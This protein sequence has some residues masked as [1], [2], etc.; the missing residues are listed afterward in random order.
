M[1]NAPAA[2]QALDV[3][4]LLAHRGEPVPAASI[5]RELGLP[6]SSVY[7]LLAVLRERGFV[8]HLDA[9]RRYGLGVAAYELGTAY[10]RQAPLARLARSTLDRLVDTTGHN[11]HLA[12]LHG[13]DVLYVIEQRAPRRPTLVTDV[14]VRLP[15]T[16]TATGLAMLAALP[17]AQVRALFPHSDALVQRDG[18]GPATTAQ[19]RSVLQAV[20]QRGH[21]YEEGLVT[22]GLHSIAM[23][24]R[25]HTGHPVAAVAVTYRLEDLDDRGEAGVIEAVRVAAGSLTRRLGGPVG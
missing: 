22:G 24:V 19:L 2:A 8:A 7:H 6:R 17:A 21:A 9:E 16:V 14:G 11:A 3:L 1:A 4:S 12:I 13:R 20:R 10:Q 18:K 23:A 15:A 5:A 25:D